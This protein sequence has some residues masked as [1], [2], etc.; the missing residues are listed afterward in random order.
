MRRSQTYLRAFTRF[1]SVAAIALVA[2]EA[3]HAQTTD[4]TAP[5][6]DGTSAPIIVTAQRRSESL[7]DVP[8]SL[9]VHSEE[10][11]ENAVITDIGDLPLITPGI[12]ISRVIASNSPYIRGIG[13]TS[14]LTGVEP[15]VATY[16]DG[17][18]QPASVG[19]IF[20]FSN[21]SSIEILKGPQGT[22]YGRN[23]T[24]GVINII[25][26]DPAF[27]TQ[28]EGTIGYSNYDT[29]TGN[30]YAT[31]PVSES[32]AVDLSVYYLDQNNGFGD[33]LTLNR[34]FQTEEEVSVRGR[35]L[36]E[37]D[38]DT[39]IRLS[40][41][42]THIDSD[43][44]VGAIPIRDGDDGIY[45][46]VDFYD[47][48]AGFPYGALVESY[49]ISGQL[50]HDF[51]GVTLKL[52]SAYRYVDSYQQFS[53][54]AEPA[55]P[56]SAEVR[57]YNFQRS[58]S[59]ELQ[60]SSSDEGPISWVGGLFYLNDLAVYESPN[61]FTVDALTPFGQA[62]VVNIGSR[63][64]LE[65]VSGY[66][67]ASWEFLPGTTLTGGIR[68]TSD[69]RHFLGVQNPTQTIAIVG[70]VPTIVP[71]G[72]RITAQGDSTDGKLTYR[73][74]LSH[75]FTDDIMAYASYTTG[76][77]S[78]GFAGNA[79]TNPP[80]RPENVEA[81]E[82]GFRGTFDNV[83]VSGAYFHYNYTDLQVTRIV[84]LAPIS[85]NAAGAQIDGF[86]LE[87]TWNVLPGF[88][89][90]FGGQYLDARY[91][92]YTNVPAYT[93]VPGSIAN[94]NATPIDA[95]G[96]RL[97][98]APELTFNLG[99]SYRTSVG[100][101]E[102]RANVNYFY[103]DGYNFY[104]DERVVQDSFNIL[105]ARLGFFTEDERFGI[106]IFGKNLTNARYFVA[107]RCGATAGDFASYGE[108]RRYGVEFSTRF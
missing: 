66:F 44:G 39:E 36:I 55:T 31:G 53:Q 18:Y 65:S 91:T 13:T 16:V 82:L 93:P 96:N 80:L 69:N 34:E 54:N 24:G 15:A 35:V 106:S 73:A 32:I 37:A 87:G 4:E 29:W 108:P 61:G 104:A 6:I 105:N 1:S 46:N 21:I 92:D 60:L 58:I 98:I 70:G 40:A 11:L 14:P 2:M 68:Y 88:D 7:A 90:T 38:A 25:T 41:D 20:A 99:A 3:A 78:G 76:F 77:K 79:P 71:V 103:N 52:I 28:F 74:V 42:Y 30:M 5:L 33:Y 47:T 57:S 86:E 67:D 50:D 49:G 81:F 56:S 12:T 107:C 9:Q 72:S 51:G 17:I 100:S 84:G 64:K 10:A 48:L 101:G 85:E 59:N 22:L 8:L 75:H 26:R 95:T 27:D 83:R 94:A 102:L 89:L 63:Q 97:R 19:N 43:K 23:A 62:R 45:T